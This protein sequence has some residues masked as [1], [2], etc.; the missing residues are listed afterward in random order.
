MTSQEA[1]EENVSCLYQVLELHFLHFT[2]QYKEESVLRILP[3]LLWQHPA[4]FLEREPARTCTPLYTPYTPTG[5]VPEASRFQ[6]SSCLSF[7]NLLDAHG[8]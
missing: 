6:A 7:S 5:S 8:R 2:A 4:L 1:R 3:D